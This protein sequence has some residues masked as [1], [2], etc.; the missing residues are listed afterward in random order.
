MALPITELLLAAYSAA[1]DGDHAH[2]N[3]RRR[4]ARTH[5][6][7]STVDDADLVRRFRAGDGAAYEAAIRAYYEWLRAVAFGYVRSD[8][9]AEE[10]VDSAFA[11]AWERRGAL[12]VDTRLSVY[13]FVAVRHAA[14]NHVK[15]DAMARRRL[16]LASTNEIPPG[17]GRAPAGPDVD[18]EHAEVI[19]AVWRAIETLPER[20]QAI[21][22]LRW[23]E[24]RD[25]PEIAL[26]LGMSQGAV[27]MQHSRALK[28]LRKRLASVL[29][30]RE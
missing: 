9:L 8:V 21:L 5:T 6:T 15:R 18:V 20:T 17:M 2:D 25:W 29:G 10:I 28:V 1:E 14:L 11:R 23:R 16:A 12:A 27:Q 30:E 22:A 4:A 19:A 24:Q 3:E 13:L 26:Q 7:T